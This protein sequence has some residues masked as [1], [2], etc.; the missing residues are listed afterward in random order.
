MTTNDNLLTPREA[1]DQLRITE[2]TLYRWIEQNLIS[3]I[4]VGPG[5]GGVVR[6]RKSALDAY[7]ERNTRGV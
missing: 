5:R 3:T 7:L 2:R 1:A 4:K 6:I